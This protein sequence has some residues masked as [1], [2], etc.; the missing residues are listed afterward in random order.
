MLQDGWVAGDGS[1]TTDRQQDC[2]QSNV[3]SNAVGKTLFVFTRKFH[4]CDWKD[5]AIEVFEKKLN[6]FDS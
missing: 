1:L 6:Q 3:Y 2:D 4:T 5:Y